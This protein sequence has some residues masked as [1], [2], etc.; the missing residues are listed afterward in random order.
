MKFFLA[1]LGNW[2]KELDIVKEA[3]LEAD[4]L[5][6]DGA[7]VPDHYMWGSREPSRRRPDDYVT[8]DSWVLLTYLAA[9]TEQIR[10]G[11]RVTPIPF[12]PPG[13]LAK[14]VSTLD[15]LSNG[16]VIL[17]VGAGWSKEEFEGYSEWN[18]PKIRVDKTFEGLEL[19][20]KLWTQKEVTFEGKYYR[21]KAAVLEPKPVQKP[22]PT[23]LF[24][25]SGD[26]MLRLAGKYGNICYI[27]HTQTPEEFEEGKKK[28]LRVAERL[29]RTDKI[30][31]MI[32]ELS[33]ISY[34]QKE[35]FRRVEE[36]IEVGASYFQ[37][38][39]PR[40]E[41]LINSVRRFAGE[42]IPSFK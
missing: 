40:N 10:L 19:I 5:G 32:G 1:G 16:R 35:Y 13:M 36:A 18:G 21:A 11:T 22:Y 31:F 39:F 33:R 27:P 37:A 14:M 12:R 23:L 42:I 29:N 8:L 17:G 25:S 3:I 7:L 4:R 41:L 9:K 24:G 6:F 34:D 15:I 38:S 30:A 28:V 26:R 2:Y 20:V